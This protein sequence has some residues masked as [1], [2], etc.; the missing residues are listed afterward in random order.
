[1]V[2]AGNLFTSVVIDWRSAP[3]LALD[4]RKKLGAGRASRRQCRGGGS[5]VGGIVVAGDFRKR[6]QHK[7]YWIGGCGI[8]GTCG[9]AHAGVGGGGADGSS[10]N[11]DGGL[12]ENCA[13][14][15]QASAIKPTAAF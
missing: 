2:F 6:A 1:V 4:P 14:R 11:G 10:G 8:C 9:L 7:R 13:R 15:F 12:K 3:V 5:F